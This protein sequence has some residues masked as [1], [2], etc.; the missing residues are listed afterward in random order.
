MHHQVIK[1]VAL[2]CLLVGL[3]APHPV[4]PAVYRIVQVDNPEPATEALFGTSVAGLGD[5]DGDG[6]GEFAAGAPGTNRVYVMSG[7]DQSVIHTL[8]DPYAFTGKRFGYSVRGVGDMNGD[9]IEEIAVGA[10]GNIWGIPSACGYPPPLECL[11]QLGRVFVF[12][13]STGDSLLWYGDTSSVTVY[14]NYIGTTLAPLGD[15]NVLCTSSSA[16]RGSRSPSSS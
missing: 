16:N 14:A 12:S 8:Q 7:A 1:A 9:G 15:V 6:I 5:L 13:G 11:A 4:A 10:P 2:T 3:S